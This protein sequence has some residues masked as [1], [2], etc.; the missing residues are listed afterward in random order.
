MGASP[1][2]DPGYVGLTVTEDDSSETGSR[3][4][5]RDPLLSA[6]EALLLADGSSARLT[7]SLRREDLTPS[8]N[9]GGY[10]GGEDTPSRSRT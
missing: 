3:S 8:A 1:D 6:E 7:W 10:R 9:T 5:P 4:A 2:D